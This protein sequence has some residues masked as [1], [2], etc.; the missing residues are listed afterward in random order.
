MT[1]AT[2]IRRQLENPDGL[3]QEALEPLA[4]EYRHA[5]ELVNERLLACIALLRK[6]LRSEALQ[7]ANIKP[8][9]FDAAAELDFPEV[10]DWIDILRFYG[11]NTPPLVDANAIGELNEALV[12]EQPLEEL[13]RQHRRLAIAKA[14]LSW[15]LRVLR[16]IAQIDV[17]NTVWYDDI[18]QWETIRLKQIAIELGRAIESNQSDALFGLEE[19]LSYKDWKVEVP[20]QL[21]QK[22]RIASSRKAQEQRIEQAKVI[23]GKLHSAIL[24]GN[25][26]A[27]I[28]AAETWKQLIASAPHTSSLPAELTQD[29]APALEW[30]GSILRQR[31]AENEYNELAQ[32]LDHLLMNPSSNEDELRQAMHRL[33]A[34]DFEV[35]PSI[36]KRFNAKLYEFSAKERR[37][38]LLRIAGVAVPVVVLLVLGL[39]WY[40][41]RSH[42][43]SVNEASTAMKSML[44]SGKLKE[45]ETFYRNLSRSVQ[46]SPAV[47]ALAEEM[48]GLLETEQSRQDQ[49]NRL[50]GEADSE[51]PSQIDVAKINQAGK[52][53]KT[54]EENNRLGKLRQRWE[55]FQADL[56]SKDLQSV[57][58]F[59][60]QVES[61][62]NTMQDQPAENVSAAQL[63]SV[64]ID[65][66]QLSD[67]Y[68]KGGL[69]AS[70]LIDFAIERAEKLRTSVQNK[71]RMML[72]LSGIMDEIRD[73]NSIGNYAKHLKR[74][75]ERLSDSPQAQELNLVLR[76][77]DKWPLIE[78]LN[79][80]SKELGS[81]FEQILTVGE[82]FSANQLR[83]ELDSKILNLPGKIPAE[84]FQVIARYVGARERALKDL[85]DEAM[86]S[87]FSGLV[88]LVRTGTNE[89]YFTSDQTRV[90]FSNELTN[91]GPTTKIDLPIVLDSSG[92]LGTNTIRGKIEIKAEP[93]NTVRI[94]VQ[95][96]G[97]NQ[98]QTLDRWD[99]VFIRQIGETLTNED[100]DVTIKRQL[101]LMLVETGMK[102][103]R[104]MDL[105]FA[106]SKVMLTNEEGGTSWF[107]EIK[108]DS[109]LNESLVA[110]LKKSVAEARRIR[111]EDQEVIKELAKPK[112]VFIGGVLPK[113]RSVF[114]P[115][116]T[117]NQP[118]DGTVY[119]LVGTP[120]S[121]IK[122]NLIPIGSLQ[123]G[124]FIRNN[125]DNP[126]SSIAWAP[127]LCEPS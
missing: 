15:R 35:D 54:K 94:L 1:L 40:W 110:E 104:G 100:L 29:A 103:S 18:V 116:V 56:E 67:R 96:V 114:E 60:T 6:G 57:Q 83:T 39:L 41:N 90:R 47:S 66:R 52:L 95:G 76:Q 75:S 118:P 62:L 48:A 53:A 9:I 70:K 81:K 16:R 124:T 33:L 79:G 2:R 38:Q 63:D 34:T 108:F 20:E 5:V 30:V 14:P 46:S 86:R 69:R 98:A 51:D 44:D 113:D 106:P 61:K 45:T 58:D 27:G 127:L 23:A 85:K 24:E 112:L 93:R 50:I 99:E 31:V 77:A 111:T 17:M 119:M 64:L 21:R 117:V 120:Q 102:G 92:N 7:R 121:S 88:T 68:P 10:D 107:T 42:Q 115:T 123:S 72:Q 13:L 43:A 71:Q 109:R 105:A 22:C 36:Q 122:L 59:V 97:T 125:V 80:L 49:L 101:I 87:P 28:A 73:S 55:D 8:N 91:A 32:Q 26:D 126:V 89:R 11:M 65:L 19:E 78:K 4:Q 37:K 3:T 82:T 25:V 12:D 74:Y 84:K